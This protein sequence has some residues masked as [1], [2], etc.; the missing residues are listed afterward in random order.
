MGTGCDADQLGDHVDISDPAARARKAMLTG[1]LTYIA[2]AIRGGFA[3]DSA[4]RCPR[5]AMF[6]PRV[7]VEPNQLRSQ[8]VVDERLT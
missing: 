7:F 2:L 6:T 1:S 5:A 4:R 3:A 8:N